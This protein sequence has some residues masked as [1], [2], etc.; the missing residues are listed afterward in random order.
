[1]NS[2]VAAGGV[3][4]RRH[5]LDRRRLAGAVVSEECEGLRLLHRVGDALDRGEG[6][7]L[8]FWIEYALN[9]QHEV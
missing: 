3:S 2:R 9:P 5:H 1:M 8:H 7:W 4:L 6:L